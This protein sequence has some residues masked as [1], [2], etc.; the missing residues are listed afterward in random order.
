MSFWVLFV[1]HAGDQVPR[2]LDM[3]ETGAIERWAHESEVRDAMVDA[4]ADLFRI[5]IVGR[6][7]VPVKAVA[8]TTYELVDDGLREE[9]GILPAV[10]AL[11]QR[12]PRREDWLRG[13][14][15][16]PVY[17]FD[18]PTGA[19]ARQTVFEKRGD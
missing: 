10:P 2:I 12:Q 15:E 7:L 18:Q 11:P 16:P 5:D 6:R 1:P 3:A 17:D 13:D 14:D 9:V 8:R 4:K 19:H